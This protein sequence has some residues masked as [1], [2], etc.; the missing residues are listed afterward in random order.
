MEVAILASLCFIRDTAFQKYKRK[1]EEMKIHSTGVFL[2][3]ACQNLLPEKSFNLRL[4]IGL[5]SFLFNM[6]EKSVNSGL[7]KAF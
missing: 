1:E 7:D 3:W 5:W 2:Y 4:K 6:S